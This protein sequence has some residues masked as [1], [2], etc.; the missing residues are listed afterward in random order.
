MYPA[1]GAIAVTS[2]LGRFLPTPLVVATGAGYALD[3][4]RPESIGPIRAYAGNIA[5]LVKAYAWIRALG[6]DGL[7]EVARTAVLNNNYVQQRMT[8]LRGVS[9]AFPE[10]TERRLDVVRYSL[11]GLREETGLGA[12]ELNQR[13][14]D[15]GLPAAWASHHP[16]TSPEPLTLEP[17]ESFSRAELDELVDVYEHVIGE[18]YDRPAVIA[19]APHRS[20]VAQMRSGADEEAGVPPATAR[21]LRDRAPRRSLA[22][23]SASGVP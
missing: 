6:Q 3:S 23:A 5:S 14:P 13:V 11:S 16:H 2:R 1:A 12:E 21:L 20:A 19:A 8:G 18:A 10:N 15:F 22:P 7:R 17:T 9:L 4:D